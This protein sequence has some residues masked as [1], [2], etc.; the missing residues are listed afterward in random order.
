MTEDYADRTLQ[1]Y[2]DSL[3][4][5]ELVYAVGG[6]RG[7]EP[8]PK[9]L[10][11]RLRHFLERYRIVKA[12]AD[13][14]TGFKA[15]ALEKQD[16]SNQRIYAI[17]GVEAEKLD[18]SD[19][20][21]I[22]SFAG[23]Q[24]GGVNA[25]IFLGDAIRHVRR[26]GDIHIA[27][28]S[29]GGLIGQVMAY[30][31]QLQLGEHAKGSID[32]T[33][34]A[35]V[36][37]R[38]LT[39]Y[40]LKKRGLAFDVEIMGG[41]NAKGFY[42]DGDR[43]ARIG[44]HMEPTYAFPRPEGMSLL[45]AHFITKG[46][47]PAIQAA[48]K[49]LESAEPKT[50]ELDEETTQDFKDNLDSLVPSNI[51]F[52]LL[53]VLDDQS[54]RNEHGHRNE[55]ADQS[56]AAAATSMLA[57]APRA[58][59]GRTSHPP[60]QDDLLVSPKHLS[61][62]NKERLYARLGF[63]AEE[64]DY[65]PRKRRKVN[66]CMGDCFIKEPGFEG[67]PGK[68]PKQLGG[69]A[70]ILGPD[71]ALRLLADVVPGARAV[72]SPQRRRTAPDGTVLRPRTDAST[73][74]DEASRS[75]IRSAA[76]RTGIAGLQT[77]LAKGAAK[78]AFDSIGANA[79]RA[80]HLPGILGAAFGPIGGSDSPTR[81]LAGAA[82]RINSGV[83]IEDRASPTQVDTPESRSAID[84]AIQ[85]AGPD[86]FMQSFEQVLDEENF[87]TGAEETPFSAFDV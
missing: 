26:H 39:D 33:T 55:N 42:V 72:A 12:Y 75:A 65:D 82:N 59:V 43:F 20:F 67:L 21:A 6:F 27:G 85:A 18:A 56:Q 50:P 51:P 78:Q 37:G 87:G 74:L 63:H 7:T 44:T 30:L 22:M 54:S 41:I 60:A 24:L 58:D 11:P 32:L 81:A 35:A 46:I 71:S 68:L 25:G 19:A 79:M 84:R 69:I 45:D 52:Q 38:E 36:G 16:G 64:A 5:S 8:D 29:M 9:Q 40:V 15:I 4:A 62:D 23:R 47:I 61:F 2:Q 13:P 57:R 28:Q 48:P 76:D 1:S 34:W 86:K 80:A 14:G 49:G 77:A 70:A 66:E 83:G 3:R 10:S 73:A 17:A 53:D 31:A